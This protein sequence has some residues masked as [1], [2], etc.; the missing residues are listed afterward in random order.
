M[1]VTG[2]SPDGGTGFEPRDTG[3]SGQ[4]C[5]EFRITPLRSSGD[6]ASVCLEKFPGQ[7]QQGR[8]LTLHEPGVCL[9]FWSGVRLACQYGLHL[10]TGHEDGGIGFWRFLDIHP[11]W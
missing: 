5:L 3:F 10:K 2:I 7:R 1:I 9:N 4:F 6:V 8:G 11:G